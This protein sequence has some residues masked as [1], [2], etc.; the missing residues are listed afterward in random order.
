MQDRQQ[1][2]CRACGSPVRDALLPLVFAGKFEI[3]R[4]IGAGGMGVVYRARDFA[5]DRPVAIKV[6]PRIV[7]QAAARLRRE[8][9]AMATIHHANLAVIHAMEPWRGARYSC[10]STCRAGRSR[11]AFGMALLPSRTF[12]PPVS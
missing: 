8:A 9:R 4:Q 1:P 7:P 6:L 11:I 12:L 5:L 2:S 3:E 10:S